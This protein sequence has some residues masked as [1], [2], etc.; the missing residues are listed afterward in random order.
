MR[1]FVS[2]GQHPLID[3]HKYKITNVMLLAI[4]VSYK[5]NIRQEMTI[6]IDSNELQTTVK[7]TQRL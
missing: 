3:T 1:N 4:N 6:A 7:I 5:T 2:V